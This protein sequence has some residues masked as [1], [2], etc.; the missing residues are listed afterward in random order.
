MDSIPEQNRSEVDDGDVPAHLAR[1]LDQSAEDLRHGRVEDA[2]TALA[3]LERRLADHLARKRDTV[4][5][6]HRD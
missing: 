2:R 4:G 1:A 6:P 3:K 5:A